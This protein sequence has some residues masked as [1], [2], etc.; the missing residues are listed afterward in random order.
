MAKEKKKADLT[1]RE[2][3]AMGGNAR[4]EGMTPERRAAIAKKAAAAR[5]GAKKKAAK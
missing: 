5:W 4:A 2:L 1:V 3:A